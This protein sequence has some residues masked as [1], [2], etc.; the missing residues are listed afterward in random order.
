MAYEPEGALE[1]A[2]DA[3]GIVSGRVEKTLKQF[4]EMLERLR[5]RKEKP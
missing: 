5:R 1:N 4:K 3:I 2:G